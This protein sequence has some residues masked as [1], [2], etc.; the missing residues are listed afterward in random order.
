MSD[1]PLLK[2]LLSQIL[3]PKTFYKCFLKKY[4]NV[5]YLF[6]KY[7][8]FTFNRDIEWKVLF[9]VKNIL[10]SISNQRNA[11]SFLQKCF[12]STSSRDIE[13][14]YHTPKHI[15]CSQFNNLTWQLI[16]ASIHSPISN[17]FQYHK[18]II[19]MFTQVCVC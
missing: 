13:W 6:Q 16:R 19:D 1:Y 15:I 5:F 12:Y 14:K 11:F 9:A 3:R 17:Y 4:V 2:I 18:F 8:Y 7:F 10:L